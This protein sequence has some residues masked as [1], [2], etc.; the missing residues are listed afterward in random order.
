MDIVDQGFLDARKVKLNKLKHTIKRI[1]TKIRAIFWPP[2]WGR[3]FVRGAE[4]APREEGIFA[5]SYHAPSLGPGVVPRARPEQICPAAHSNVVAS[6]GATAIWSGVC[7]HVRW[8]MERRWAQFQEGPRPGTTKNCMGRFLFA[9][10]LFPPNYA[11]ST[12]S[13]KC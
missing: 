10:L 4:C 13:K 12:L 2:F 7:V 3:I 9:S 1:G 5:L 6:D 8:E 11:I